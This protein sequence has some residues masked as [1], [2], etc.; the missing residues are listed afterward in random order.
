V[1]GTGVG[2][3]PRDADRRITIFRDG[4]KLWPLSSYKHNILVF[5]KMN[6]GLTI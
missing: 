1:G 3:G 6:K 2:F 4:F 5:L